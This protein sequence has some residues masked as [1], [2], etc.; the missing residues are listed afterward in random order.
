MAFTE[1]ASVYFA[2]FATPATLDG[3]AVRGVFDNTYTLELGGVS[4]REPAYT[5]P[6]AACAAVTR[7][8]VLVVP[9]AG[10]YRV[11]EHEPDGTGVSVLRLELQ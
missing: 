1:D 8:S 4:S 11:R 3:V 5:L 10:T 2:D 9:A 6:T 7:S